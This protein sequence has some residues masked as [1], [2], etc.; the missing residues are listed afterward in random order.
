MAF[1]AHGAHA[2]TASRKA[3]PSDV[4]FPVLHGTFGGT[5]P[6]RGSS[7]GRHRYVGAAVLGSAAGHGQGRDERACS[8]RPA[9][10]RQAHHVLR[11]GWERSPRKAVARLKRRSSTALCEAPRTSGSRSAS[12]RSHDP[13]KWARALDLA[14]KI[15]PQ[16]HREQ[17]VGGGGQGREARVSVLG[18][19][20]PKAS[21]VGESFPARSSRLRGQVSL[22]RLGAVI[23]P[24]SP[25]VRL[26]KSS[27]W[28]S[29]LSRLRPSAFAVSTSSW[30]RA[31]KK[32]HLSQ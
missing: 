4:V 18:N 15:R 9:C 8:P 21:V 31:G 25:R 24:N 11:A 7:S 26:N 1:H 22:R 27:R 17:G 29:P 6:S 16:A 30:T 28:Q 2:R 19:D 3:K 23:P 12:A 5:A 13:A 14:A 10:H 32:A 20:D